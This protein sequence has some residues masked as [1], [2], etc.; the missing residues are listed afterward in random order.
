MTKSKV[1]LTRLMLTLVFCFALV[2]VSTALIAIGAGSD[3]A[4]AEEAPTLVGNVEILSGAQGVSKVG[5]DVVITADA[6]GKEVIKI[7]YN[8]TATN[9]WYLKVQLSKVVT[10][11]TDAAHTIQGSDNKYYEVGY[12]V[13]IFT[14]TKVEVNDITAVANADS[15]P[16]HSI[17]EGAG[18]QPYEKTIVWEGNKYD[19]KNSQSLESKGNVLV[20]TYSVKSTVTEE[21]IDPDTYNFGLPVV[22]YTIGTSKTDATAGKLTPT[23][24]VKVKHIGKI[25]V[26]STASFTYSGSALTVGASNADIVYTYNGAGKTG[27]GSISHQWYSDS[28]YADTAKIS[29]SE[30]VDA[31][32][33]YLEITA[34]EDDNYTA[35]SARVAVTITQKEISFAGFKPASYNYGNA[36][37]PAFSE[38]GDYTYYALNDSTYSETNAG[39]YDVGVKLKDTQNTKWADTYTAVSGVITVEWTISKITLNITLPSGIDWTY[40]DQP[41]SDALKVKA[42]PTFTDTQAQSDG[43]LVLEYYIN[44]WDIKDGWDI[45]SSPSVGTNGLL[46]KVRNVGSQDNYEIE[47]GNCTVTIVAK[48]ISLTISNLSE[49]SDVDPNG[50]WIITKPFK[51][52]NYTWEIGDFSVTAS[53]TLAK[54]LNQIVSL[55]PNQTIF[56][57]NGTLAGSEFTPYVGNDHA[58]EYKLSFSVIDS[59]Y[60]L[61]GNTDITV[62]IYQATNIVENASEV[63]VVKGA[64]NEPVTINP[65]PEFAFGSATPTFHKDDKGETGAIENGSFEK[66]ITYYAVYK[67]TG[68]LDYTELV[69]AISFRFDMDAVSVKFGDNELSSGE[70]AWDTITGYAWNNSDKLTINGEADVLANGKF[71]EFT[72]TIAKYVSDS[73]SETVSSWDNR[74]GWY[75]ITLHLNTGYEWSTGD[76]ADKVYRLKINRAALT[77]TLDDVEVVVDNAATYSIKDVTL[78]NGDQLTNY[79]TI[80]WANY[81]NSPYNPSDLGSVRI[82]THTLPWVDDAKSSLEA[83]LYNY[84]LTLEAGSIQV[85]RA[86]PSHS[87]FNFESQVEYDGDRQVLKQFGTLSGYVFAGD[88]LTLY[89]YYD[90]DS[91]GSWTLLGS[92]TMNKSGSITLT[93][94]NLVNLLAP[95]VVG[96]HSLQL[97]ISEAG[98][99]TGLADTNLNNDITIAKDKIAVH[100]TIN[101]ITT[102]QSADYN[103]EK[104]NF[105]VSGYETTYSDLEFVVTSSAQINVKRGDNGVEAYTVTLTITLKSG[106]DSEYYTINVNGRPLNGNGA[107]EIEKAL[108]INP[109]TLTVKAANKESFFGAELADFGWEK[110]SGT[111]YKQNGVDD[112]TQN[113]ANARYQVKKQNDVV[114]LTKTS[115]VGT[116]TIEIV[117]FTH[118]NYDISFAGQTGTYEIKQATLKV[119][120]ISF[121][122]ANKTITWSATVEAENGVIPEG[123]EIWYQVVVGGSTQLQLSTDLSYTISSKGTYTVYA[124]VV[125]GDEAITNNVEIKVIGSIEAFEVTFAFDRSLGQEVINGLKETITQIPVTEL[126][127]KNET[128]SAPVISEDYIKVGENIYKFSMWSL[129]TTD[130]SEAKPAETPITQDTTFYAIFTQKDGKYTVTYY[131]T[132]L[133]EKSGDSW[134]YR[135]V[136]TVEIE[137]GTSLAEH[138]ATAAGKIDWFTVSTWYTDKDRGT[139]APA[140]MIDDDLD[141]YGLAVFKLGKGDVNGD[142]AVTTDDVTQFCKVI[143]GGHGIV[144]V[145]KGDEWAYATNDTYK[146]QRAG[147]LCFLECNSEISDATVSELLNLTLLRMSIVDGYGYTVQDNGLGGKEIVESTQ[148]STEGEDVSNGVVEGD[149]QVSVDESASS[150]V[151]SSVYPVVVNDDTSIVATVQ[152]NSVADD[153]L[154]KAKYALHNVTRK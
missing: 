13:N 96:A 149:S 42:N 127:F 143:V 102:Q 2:A 117:E 8:L 46:L 146:D 66:G 14:L 145:P 9:L 22:E 115:D 120:G 148:A 131:V 111:I 133:T 85:D 64:Y 135:V 89:V 151:V 28:S 60:V 110:V 150:A 24:S 63:R 36:V 31:T 47:F 25:E 124:V 83:I 95:N 1:S 106:L 76:S 21:N 113:Y 11:N 6:A 30:V 27:A 12:D 43:T 17:T 141:L 82:G 138:N 78:P 29:D 74:A 87:G 90:F 39:T 58:K 15:T 125:D 105:V 136:Y 126:Y 65:A 140:D 77:L 41:T 80:T 53:A 86:T 73:S 57:A 116:Y 147:N 139:A 128:V 52:A 45:T 70:A 88:F 59:N 119:T 144:V 91:T 132:N 68:T 154:A 123:Y 26:A 72:V 4:M 55:S 10:S 51:N 94:L 92:I 62:Q 122:A 23:N 71:T 34:S 37:S 103:G 33:Y 137:Y 152:Y 107:V 67:I 84:T 48:Q 18:V 108:K 112:I 38:T 114:S 32:T 44:N 40:S 50:E 99:D 19:A 81:V 130:P 121:S 142:G 118:N 104:H 129:T 49:L 3:K 97:R 20:L 93:S 75:I 153:V 16:S 69:Y 79:G 56:N 134:G 54:A 98:E 100:K 35:A 101:V 61:T 7:T 109:A 5:D